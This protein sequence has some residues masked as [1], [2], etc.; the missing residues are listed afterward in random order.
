[1]GWVLFV[2]ADDVRVPETSLVVV[3]VTAV[4]VVA[5]SGVVSVVVVSEPV[6]VCVTEVVVESMVLF[7]LE[8]VVFEDVG[9]VVVFSEVDVSLIDEEVGSVVEVST[10]VFPL[11]VGAVFF[12][13]ESKYSFFASA[14]QAVRPMTNIGVTLTSAASFCRLFFVVIT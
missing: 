8:G 2:S 4:G 1:M 5:V 7:S 10:D 11:V 12:S 9:D 6:S 13:R 14:P 3:V